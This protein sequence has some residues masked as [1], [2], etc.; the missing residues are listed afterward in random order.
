L[1]KVLTYLKI[2]LREAEELQESGSV[3]PAGE[4]A[5]ATTSG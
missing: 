5:E 2:V 3:P 4:P 1:L